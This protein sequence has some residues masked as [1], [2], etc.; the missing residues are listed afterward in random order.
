MESVAER[1]RGGEA[2]ASQGSEEV[3]GREGSGRA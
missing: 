1:P 3:V 2:L